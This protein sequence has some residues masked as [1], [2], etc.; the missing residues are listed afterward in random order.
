MEL[1][2]LLELGILVSL[3][4]VG[5]RRQ[6]ITS[7]NKGILMLLHGMQHLLLIIGLLLDGQLFSV[8]YKFENRE[9]GDSGHKGGKQAS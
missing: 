5:I 4:F 8:E 9:G 2:L 7:P 1:N 6:E 3:I